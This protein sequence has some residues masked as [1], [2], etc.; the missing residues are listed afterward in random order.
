MRRNDELVGRARRRHV[1]LE[2]LFGR[3]CPAPARAADG[4]DMP[5]GQDKDHRHLC[6]CI[7]MADTADGRAAMADRHMRNMVK[8]QPQDGIAAMNL[9]VKLKVAVAHVRTHDDLIF[10][11]G[12]GAQIVYLADVDQGRGGCQT[13]IHRRYQALAPRQN[14]R[15]IQAFQRGEHIVDG[16]STVILKQTRLHGVSPLATSRIARPHRPSRTTL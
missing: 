16:C 3:N 1:E 15:V 4:G 9:I 2:E 7:R 6:C 11:D 14:Q 13:K 8:R 5:P 12:D 10:G